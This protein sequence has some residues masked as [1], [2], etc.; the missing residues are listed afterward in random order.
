MV[1]TF[2]Q[3]ELSKIAYDDTNETPREAPNSADSLKPA[4]P[5]FENSLCEGHSAHQKQPESESIKIIL[6]VTWSS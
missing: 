5:V 4:Y 6:I 1:R 2:S 3:G